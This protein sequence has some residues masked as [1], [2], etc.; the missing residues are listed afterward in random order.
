MKTPSTMKRKRL[1][2]TNY[3][4]RLSLLKSGQH[5]LVIRVSRKG[6]VAQLVDY[7]PA[8]DKIVLTVTEKTLTKLGINLEG[9]N[10]Q[11]AYLVGYNLGLKA[12]KHKIHQAIL[13][14]GRFNIIK[15][16]RIASVL[17]GVTDAG[18]KVPHEKSVFPSKDRL[19]GKHL[20]NKVDIKATIPLMEEKI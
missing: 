7:D 8:G 19:A 18:L 2:V 10:T 4:K 12:K 17:K 14:T 9:N 6:I 16:G 1:G 11:V 13:D 20:K 3:K 5:R 15:G